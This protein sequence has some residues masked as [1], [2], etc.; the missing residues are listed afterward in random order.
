MAWEILHVAI[1]KKKKTKKQNKK[2]QPSYQPSMRCSVISLHLPVTSSRLPHFA[3]DLLCP[4]RSSSFVL[5][6]QVHQGMSWRWCRKDRKPSFTLIRKSR[7][8]G[9]V[10]PVGEKVRLETLKDMNLFAL[11]LDV[12]L[13]QEFPLRLSRLKTPLASIGMRL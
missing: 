3:R 4:A 9:R 1:T 5:L 6:W 2:T 11:I 8:E 10:P 7:R 12:N 13:F